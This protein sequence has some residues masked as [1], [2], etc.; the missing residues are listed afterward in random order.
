MP[1]EF[2]QD[3]KDNRTWVLEQLIVAERYLD[4]RMYECAD[5]CVS[6]GII[7][8]VKDVLKAWEDWCKNHPPKESISTNR[9]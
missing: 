8:D 4:P 9:L 7:N 2:R 1:P 6:E 3:S 5:Y